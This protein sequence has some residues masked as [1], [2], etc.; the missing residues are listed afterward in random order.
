MAIKEVNREESSFVFCGCSCWKISLRNA[1]GLHVANF[2]MCHVVWALHWSGPDLDLDFP[3][4]RLALYPSKSWCCLLGLGG[5]YNTA[6]SVS[7]W[8]ESVKKKKNIN[9][10]DCWTQ[11]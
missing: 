11:S 3:C 5:L 4:L 10:N 8:N 2:I 1:Y 7:V 6:E 9:K